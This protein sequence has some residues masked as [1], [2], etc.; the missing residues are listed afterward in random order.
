M[1]DKKPLPSIYWDEATVISFGG[2]SLIVAEACDH[3]N[4]NDYQAWVGEQFT[5]G[6]KRWQVISVVVLPYP[7]VL[8]SMPVGLN[9]FQVH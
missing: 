5:H 2:T 6:G 7:F 4:P 8:Q 9:V 1:V 3:G